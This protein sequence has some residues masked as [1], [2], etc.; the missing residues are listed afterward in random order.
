MLNTTFA[1]ASWICLPEFTDEN[2]QR[3]PWEH[4]ITR[5]EQ[6]A[7]LYEGE[8]LPMFRRIFD[9][10]GSVS[11]AS[12][13]FT[14]LG[15]IELWCNGR[16]VGCDEFKPGWTD[17]AKRALAYTYDLTPYLRAGSNTL[18]AIL[19]G[20]WYT[21]RIAVGT[22]HLNAPAFILALDYTDGAGDHRI[23]SDTDWT[24]RIG[25][26]VLL[27]DIWDG[28]VYDARRCGFA[29]ISSHNH[30][31]P[32]WKASTVFTDFAGEV[33]PHI[34]PTIGVREH[35]TRTAVRCTLYAETRDNGTDYGEIVPLYEGASMPRRLLPGQ[36]LILDFGQN[37]VG[38]ARLAVKGAAGTAL[39]IR[40]AEMCNDS[41]SAARGNDN[42]KGSI[43]TANYRS[44]KAKGRYILGGKGIED[45]APTFT[46]YGFRY[47]EL[48]ATAP[49]EL[50]RITGEVVGSQ[51]EE[52]GFIET[53]NAEVNAL[54]SNII[55]GMRGN[56]LSVPTDCPQRDERYGW[57]GDT[58]VF[59]RTA[60]YFGDVL[61]FFHKWLGDMRDSQ[62]PNG[63]YPDV[64]PRT[65]VVGD[66][67]A[68]WGDAGIIVPH[69]VYTM[70]GDA[71][72][73]EEHYAS[74][75]KYM[76]FLASR[77]MEGPYDR[78]GDWLA[79]EPTEKKYLSL[80]YYIYDCRLMAEMADIIGKPDRAAHFRDL[81]A[82]LVAHFRATYMPD[83]ELT[84][85]SQCAYLL[86]LAH[87][88]LPE[89]KV[90]AAKATLLAKIRDN[91]YR[92]ST[93]FIGT[94]HLA[95]TLSRIGAPGMAYSLLLQTENP[96]WLYSVRQGATTI[97][98]RWNS[99]T[100]ATGF[101]DVGMNSFNHYAYGCI[102]EWMYRYMAGIDA[103]APGFEKILYRPQPDLRAD[104]ELPEGQ[105]RIDH[106]TAA[107]ESPVGRIESEWRVTD[108]ALT[109]NVSLPAAAEAHIPLCGGDTLT[110]NGETVK[111]D[112]I[113]DGCALLELEA[114]E[115]AIVIAR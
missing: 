44:A 9:V 7:P 34:G 50:H 106:V 96:S 57:T 69:T 110:V 70:Y 73:I 38:R 11:A 48:V 78:Y 72:I 6:L 24:G 63:A 71:T 42:P 14:A 75:E 79:Y 41:G 49:V 90:E 93:G 43:Y 29:L 23:V 100:L 8:G 32:K 109:L 85:T 97:W 82:T 66:G 17:Y 4:R 26:P 25:G 86:A 20:G 103:A 61:G 74:M 31:C 22:Y 35:L 39:D 40:Y 59:C 53:S 114:G 84:Q 5:N 58:Q 104:A 80:V 56:Y 65:R 18:L 27:G 60:A 101:G 13:T 99:Y 45:Y 37:I 28:E 98:E 76:D 95:N 19:A 46:F 113:V 92:L 89:D 47:I 3:N 1:G 33:S 102:A 87:D 55:W 77:G 108:G 36:T 16:R 88:L 2:A 52:T 81:H 54:I 68:A 105:T 10:A 64:A 12:V 51:I 67:A 62:S 15:Q 112:T 115:Y 21:G 91:G 94:A 107:F 30:C 111:A 83:G